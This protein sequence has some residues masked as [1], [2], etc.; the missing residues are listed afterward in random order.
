ME[1]N[2]QKLN[3]KATD[4]D[5]RGQSA[6]NTMISHTKEEFVLD[7]INMLPP[8]PLLVQRIII[9]PGHAKRLLRALAE[10]VER[11]E[12]SFGKLEDVGAEKPN[13][14]FQAQ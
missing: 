14:G 2:S 9:H 7:F 1:Q 11:Y 13:I 3:I 10:Q 8:H 12:S 6:N 4:Q 5:L